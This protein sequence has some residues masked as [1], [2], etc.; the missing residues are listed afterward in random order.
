LVLIIGD[1]IPYIAANPLACAVIKNA[2]F[3]TSSHGRGKPKFDPAS[4][5][6]NGGNHPIRCDPEI[7][8]TF[9]K[10]TEPYEVT[11]PAGHWLGAAGL[12]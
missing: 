1:F 11:G 7:N 9:P 4:D 6:L 5:N 10:M 12:G 8:I 3:K 2:V